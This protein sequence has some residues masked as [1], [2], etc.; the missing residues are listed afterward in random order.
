MNVSLLFE[1][2]KA[3]LVTTPIIQPPNWKE[4][5]EIMCDARDYAIGAALGQRDGKNLN[6]IQYASQIFNND[7]KKY[8]TIEK[9]FLAIV[10]AC[11]KFSSY[12]INSKVKIHT[13]HQA[14]WHL[15]VKKDA[16][17][18]LIRWVLLLHEYEL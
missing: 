13:D 15:L 16:K 8:A 6:V 14:L 7:Q 10:F 11:D 12:I 9:E 5:F 4:S 2:L 1:Q 3:A 18:R 17:L